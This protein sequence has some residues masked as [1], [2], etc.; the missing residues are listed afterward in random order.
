MTVE[1]SPKMHEDNKI[2]EKSPK[3]QEEQKNEPV[4]V[5]E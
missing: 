4:Q 2:E 3:A 1:Q 5:L